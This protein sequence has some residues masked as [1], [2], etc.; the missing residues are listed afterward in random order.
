MHYQGNA[1]EKV[2]EAADADQL[3]GHRA[4]LE[5]G[6]LVDTFMTM[7]TLTQRAATGRA[8]YLAHCES[9]A[10]LVLLGRFCPEELR[11]ALAVREEWAA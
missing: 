8:S 11:D 3:R 9:V 4:S 1:E 2:L 6:E 7:H 5:N 10:V